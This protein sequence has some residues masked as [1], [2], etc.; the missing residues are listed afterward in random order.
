MCLHG[1]NDSFWR[2][3]GLEDVVDEG[4]ARIGTCIQEPGVPVGRGL[5]VGAAS[6]LGLPVGTPVATAVIDAHAGGIGMKLPGQGQR[7]YNTLI[8]TSK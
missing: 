7:Q 1:W 8:T 3:I 4:Y 6:E 2:I 5:E